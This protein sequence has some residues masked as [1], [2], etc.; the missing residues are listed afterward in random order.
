MTIYDKLRTL[1]GAHVEVNSSH[2]ASA[3]TFYVSTP[4]TPE[5]VGALIASYVVPEADIALHG[6]DL[7]AENILTYA[8]KVE[9]P[10]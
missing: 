4:C 6:Q 3:R 7:V 10:A 5:G 8:I 1:H 9:L 2:D